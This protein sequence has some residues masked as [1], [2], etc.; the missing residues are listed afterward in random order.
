MNNNNLIGVKKILKIENK[1]LAEIIK[2]SGYHNQK[3]KKLKNFCGFLF[4][5]Y[6]GKLKKL[7][8]NDIK[9]LRNE[10]LSVSGIGPETADSIILYAARKPIFV[11]DAYTKRILNRIG[12]KEETYE[13]LQRLFM[14][15][16]PNSEKLFN[17]YHALLVELGKSICKKNPLCEEC[18]INRHCDY[19]KNIYTK[20]KN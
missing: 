3:A 15:N 20:K 9:K 7:F 6:D 1:K 10:L 14:Q 5:N 12:Y 18:P 11:I 2:S 16:L 19:Y 13:E 17:E 4:R 8:E